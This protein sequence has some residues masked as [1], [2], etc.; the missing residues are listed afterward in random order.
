MDA[1]QMKQLSDEY[2]AE[3]LELRYILIGCKQRAQEGHYTYVRIENYKIDAITR[4][5]LKELGYLVKETTQYN[6]RIELCITWY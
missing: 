6:N 2:S 5:R 3:A 4:S 1:K